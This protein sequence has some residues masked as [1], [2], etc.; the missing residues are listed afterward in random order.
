MNIAVILNP[1]NIYREIEL[2]DGKKGLALC[3]IVKTVGS[4]PRKSGAKMLVWE[5]GSIAKTIG[6]G[7]LENKV[8]ENAKVVIQNGEPQLFEHR[9]NVDHG[10][11]CGGTVSIFIEPIVA[12]KKVYIFGA[13]HTGKA[14]AA[15]AHSLEFEVTLIDERV[16]IVDD[17]VLSED[18]KVIEKAHMIALKSMEFDINTYAVVVTHNHN[19]D[20]EIVA[21]CA[22]QSHGYLGMIGSQRKVEVAKQAYRAGSILTEEQMA[23]IDW[24]I[25]IDINAK[26]PEEIAISI[27]GRLIIERNKQEVDEK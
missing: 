22:Q 14:L 5:D 23:G 27:L 24:P 13:G 21:Y 2:H 18:I 25:G 17:L 1:M 3:T 10:M 8:I 7:E 11:C 26:T 12:K 15:Y 9:L 20:K 6:G 19:Y 4:S 16:E